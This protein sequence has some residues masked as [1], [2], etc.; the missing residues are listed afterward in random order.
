M[1]VLNIFYIQDPYSFC[2]L[3]MFSPILWVVFSLSWWFPFLC[4]TEIFN[5]EEVQVTYFFVACAFGV[6]SKKPLPDP[7]S[8]RFTP[9]CFSKNFIS[10]AFCKV[11]NPLCINFLIWCSVEVQLHSFLHLDIQLTQH[12]LLKRLFLPIEFACHSCQ[13]LVDC[14]FKSLFLNYQFYSID[15]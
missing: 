4:S 8:W 1:W 13:K 6:I 5:F 12:H 7:R 3:Q 14:K 11:F 2:D 10:L 15:L 9:V